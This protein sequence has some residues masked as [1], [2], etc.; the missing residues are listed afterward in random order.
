VPDGRLLPYCLGKITDLALDLFNTLL[1][2][3]FYL[4][5]FTQRPHEEGT[6]QPE[7]GGTKSDRRTNREERFRPD[8]LPL[9]VDAQ[10]NRR[11]DEASAKRKDDTHSSGG[12]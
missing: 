2:T 11:G 1:D 12:Q 6:L 5:D 4:S 10:H 7:Q 8:P 3:A 9:K